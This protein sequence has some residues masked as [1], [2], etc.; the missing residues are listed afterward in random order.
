M[1]GGSVITTG[2]GIKDDRDFGYFYSQ[3]KSMLTGFL[4]RR[5]VRGADADDM[6]QEIWLKIWKSRKRFD[7]RDFSAWMFRIARNCLID[8]SRKSKLQERMHEHLCNAYFVREREEL[9]GI[10]ALIREEEAES[11]RRCLEE[12]G[13][14]FFEVIQAQL[15]GEAVPETASRMGISEKTVYSRRNRAKK[16]LAERLQQA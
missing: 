15:A 8:E 1:R 11:T 10:Q 2:C 14:S 16:L 6:A 13:N 5:G 3:N 4:N 9:S 7:G 12:N